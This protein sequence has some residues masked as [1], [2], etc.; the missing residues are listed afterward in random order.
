MYINYCQH[1][2]YHLI[3]EKLALPLYSA[4]NQI[5][6]MNLRRFIRYSFI[7]QLL[8]AQW[9]V[10]P[11]IESSFVQ[12][13]SSGNTIMIMF[14]NQRNSDSRILYLMEYLNPEPRSLSSFVEDIVL[15]AVRG[16]IKVFNSLSIIWTHSLQTRTTLIWVSTVCDDDD[17]R[18][19]WWH[20][21]QLIQMAG[22]G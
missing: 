10:S 13:R 6:I 20:H 4:F 5:G 1:L 14:K 19:L 15:K 18:N 3:D 11:A 7:N 9:M 16:C 17:T 8:S 21:S 12:R 22:W 2:D